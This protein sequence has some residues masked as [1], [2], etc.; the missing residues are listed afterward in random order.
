M[1]VDD[2]MLKIA[3]KKAVEAGLFPRHP[4]AWEEKMNHKIMRGIIEA[5]IESATAPERH[6]DSKPP[7]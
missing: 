6:K 2:A 4:S 5:A 1:V 7:I 3:V